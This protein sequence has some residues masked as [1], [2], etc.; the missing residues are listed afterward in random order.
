MQE[1]INGAHEEFLVGKQL[2]VL[3]DT[4]DEEFGVELEEE[5]WKKSL[6]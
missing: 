3:N 1:G 5:N 2:I 4:S 6:Q